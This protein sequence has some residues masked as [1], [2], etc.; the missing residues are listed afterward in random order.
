ML[1]FFRNLSFVDSDLNLIAI[2]LII[3]LFTYFLFSFPCFFSN[4]CLNWLKDIYS[5]CFC[6]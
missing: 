2:K 6:H 4:F 1:N 3:Y 5:L